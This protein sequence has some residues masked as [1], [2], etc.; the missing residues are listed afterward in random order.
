MGRQFN[1]SSNL[2]ASLGSS[3]SGFQPTD[4]TKRHLL[5]R[6]RSLLNDP[7]LGVLSREVLQKHKLRLEWSNRKT[8]QITE[9]QRLEARKTA[10]HDM[11]CSSCKLTH[12]VSIAGK[13]RIAIIG[14]D[15][16]LCGI[17]TQR[18]PSCMDIKHYEYILKCGMTID[19]FTSLIILLYSLY[20]QPLFI[21]VLIGI[22]DL[23]K[24]RHEEDLMLQYNRLRTVLT[25]NEVMTGKKPG[26]NVLVICKLPMVPRIIG[27]LDPFSNLLS[28]KSVMVLKLN[29][30]IL[31]LNLSMGHEEDAVPDLERH[32]QRTRALPG[33]RKRRSFKRSSWRETKLELAVHWS[34]VARFRA[35]EIIT[36]N[37]ALQLQ[38]QDLK[39]I[40]MRNENQ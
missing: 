16:M 28:P 32:G 30:R 18:E 9:L 1:N 40:T 29:R 34:N 31:H 10:S 6:R 4:F 26:A 22:D 3:T 23:L 20:D 25:E 11:L 21:M 2:T 8:F 7:R 14:G 15:S 13:K 24:G 39:P 19:E 12:E 38:S 35:H 27:K 37:L 5:L 17:F 33:G 36:F